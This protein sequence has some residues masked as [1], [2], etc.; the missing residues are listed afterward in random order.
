MTNIEKR[1]ERLNACKHRRL[2]YNAMMNLA[3]II[4]EAEQEEQRQKLLEAMKEGVE[5]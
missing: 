1:T 4:R 2:I 3:P 5:A